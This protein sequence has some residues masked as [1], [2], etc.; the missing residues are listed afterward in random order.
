MITLK[1]YF[2]ILDNRPYKFDADA[3]GYQAAPAGSVIRCAGCLHYF[4]RAI[5]GFA[6]CEIFR[7]EETDRDGVRPDY[8]CRFQTV[9]GDVFPLLP[10]EE[11]PAPVAEEEDIPY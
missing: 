11:P 1:R 6:V 3:V 4:R 9:D 2:E 5:D 8:R 7:S 10:E